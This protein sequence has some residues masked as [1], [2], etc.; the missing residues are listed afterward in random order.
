M[1]D[2]LTAVP[3]TDSA[4]AEPADPPQEGTPTPDQ[5]TLPDW[6]RE[7]LTKANREA[8]KYRTE[9][10]ANADAAKRL[11]EIEEANKSEADKAAERLAAAEQRARELEAK[12]VRAEI[13]GDVGI[14]AEILSGPADQ[15]TESLQGFAEKVIAWRDQS[16]PPP[17]A[18][19]VHVP[20]E[21]KTAP[22]V[23]IDDQI[24]EAE[25]S[26][27]HRLAIHFK[28]QKARSS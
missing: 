14:P 10:K 12:A 7:K 26:G 28:R 6:V 17:P 9:A 16:A 11:A 1:S 4:A 3:V 27:N 2:D 23:S 13:A 5:D 15:S 25:R 18:T 22:S 8:A 21:G 24:A 19:G 20:T